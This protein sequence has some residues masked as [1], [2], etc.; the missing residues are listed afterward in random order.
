VKIPN[1][2]FFNT[3]IE[4][5]RPNLKKEMPAHKHT[6]I[7]QNIKQMGPENK[8]HLSHNNSNTKCTEQRKSIEAVR[9]KGH[10]PYK[11]R[12]IRITPDF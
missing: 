10:V 5:N 12:S 11:G 1:S 3:I 6:G 4:E 8:S 2:N 9:K 7:I